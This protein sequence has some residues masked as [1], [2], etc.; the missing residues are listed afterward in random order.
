MTVARETSPMRFI[1]HIKH[2][3]YTNIRKEVLNV[4]FL[5]DMEYY[6]KYNIIYRK[7][8]TF[9]KGETVERM[10]T[11]IVEKIEKNDRNCLL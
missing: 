5:D 9:I 10:D 3:Y 4:F 8:D 2:I 7:I 1:I 11:R 6:M